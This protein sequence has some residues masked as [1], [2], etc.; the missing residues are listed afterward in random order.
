MRDV[1]IHATYRSPR[2]TPWA[3]RALAA[4]LLSL[5][6]SSACAARLHRQRDAIADEVREV[7][8][9]RVGALVRG[10]FATLD[11]LL[12]DDLTYTHSDGR[13]QSKSELLAA[14]RSGAMT[15]TGMQHEDVVV[16]TYGE[17]AVLT[18]R[19][20][21]TVRRGRET[22][23]RFPVRFTLVYVKRGG[24]WRMAAWQSTRIP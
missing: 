15:Y 24:H 4:L 16:A 12:S 22:E 9:Q 18:G 23:L 13:V 8:R 6:G 11:R 2:R 19:S 20:Q 21:I 17:T 10:D 5:L 1:T 14:L 7:E 3:T